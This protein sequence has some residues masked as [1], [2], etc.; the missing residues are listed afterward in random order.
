MIIKQFFNPQKENVDN[1]VKVIID[2]IIKPYSIDNRIYE[3]GK[4]NVIILKFEY[5]EAMQALQK[6]YLYEEQNDN[7]DSKQILRIN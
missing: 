5:S 3:T 4:E 7:R 6:L 1:S 2:E